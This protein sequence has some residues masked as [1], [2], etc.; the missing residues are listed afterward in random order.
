MDNDTTPP[1]TPADA[2][3]ETKRSQGIVSISDYLSR[4]PG[5]DAAMRDRVLMATPIAWNIDNYNGVTETP[6]LPMV[7]PLKPDRRELMI[8]WAVARLSESSTYRAFFVMLGVIG[9]AVTPE[10]SEAL[11]A[12][13]MGMSAC[14][15][16]FFGDRPGGD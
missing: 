9:W 4:R 6:G 2:T 1:A 16:L 10:Q 3:D 8:R 12:L 13:G 7:I 5:F 15:G 11:M 14:I